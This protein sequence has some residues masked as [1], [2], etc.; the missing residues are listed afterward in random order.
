VPQSC[1]AGGAWQDGNPCPFVCT[2]GSCGGSCVPGATQCANG[3]RQIC[4]AG[5]NW[6]ATA[7]PPVQLLANPGFDAGHT[8]WTE[9]T[10]SASLII[11]SDATLMSLKAQTPSYLAWLGGYPN[12]Q[13]ELSQTVTVPAGATSITLSFYY[14][15]GTAETTMGARDTMDVYTYDPV[16]AAYTTVASFNDDMPAS[17]WARFTINL[18]TSLAGRTFEVGFRATTDGAKNT[19]FFVDSVSL[20]VVACTP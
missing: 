11:T 13:D 4:D 19:N 6:Q 2:G 3:Q 9:T 18:P 7:S 16:T 20:D 15:I 12:A 14:A 8:A 5:G 17:S 10:L 1:N